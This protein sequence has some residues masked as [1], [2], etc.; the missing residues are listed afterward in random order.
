MAKMSLYIDTVEFG[1]VTFGLAKSHPGLDF[2]FRFR[3]PPPP[4][5]GGLRRAGKSGMTNEGSYKITPQESHKLLEFLDDFLKK[6]KIKNP[7]SEI[8][9]IVIYKKNTGSFTGLR[10]A[11]A[12][13]QALSLAW[14]VPAKIAIKN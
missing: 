12:I 1:K 7:Q 14:T 3:I 4:A 10:I 11:A 6:A 8:K 13:A 2:G 9:K 5:S